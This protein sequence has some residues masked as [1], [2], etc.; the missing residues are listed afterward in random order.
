MP[1]LEDTADTGIF[2]GAYVHEV[3]GAKANFNNLELTT[4][5]SDRWTKVGYDWRAVIK[6]WDTPRRPRIFTFLL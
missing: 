4:V 6:D 2:S 1:D 5:G 3:E